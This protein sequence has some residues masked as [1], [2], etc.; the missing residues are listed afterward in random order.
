MCFKFNHEWFNPRKRILKFLVHILRPKT[1]SKTK[2]LGKIQGKF[3]TNHK[4]SV[5]KLKTA[6]AA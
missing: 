5:I 4:G 2:A 6:T 3:E 1:E